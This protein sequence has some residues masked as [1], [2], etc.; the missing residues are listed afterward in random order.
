MSETYLRAATADDQPVIQRLIRD[1]RLNP[2]GIDWPRFIMAERHGQIVGAAQIKL[3]DGGVPELASLV[4]LPTQQSSGIGAALVWT[5]I[6]RSPGPI[7]LRCASHNEGYYRRFGF[8]TLPLEQMPPPLRRAYHIGDAAIR[9]INWFSGG[10]ERLLI[11]G[12]P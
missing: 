8:V 6:E 9:L 1:A 5:L 12:R 10:Q 2:F 4:V 11:M 7:Y 3:L